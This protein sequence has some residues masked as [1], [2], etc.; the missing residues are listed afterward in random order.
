[1]NISKSILL[2]AFLFLTSLAA[3]SQQCK[4]G[5]LSVPDE[6][7]AYCKSSFIDKINKGDISLES[8]RSTNQICWEVYSDKSENSLKTKPNGYDNGDRLDYMEKVVVKE[9]RGNWLWVYSRI[10][11]KNRKVEH[12]KERGWIKSENLILSGYS[13]L[14]EKSTP[15]K[16]MILV[17]LS[18]IDKSSLHTQQILKNIF[19]NKPNAEAKNA[20]GREARKFEIYFILK[21]TAGAVL[22]SKTDKLN[23]TA[24]QLESNVP[25]WI[26]K[27][28]VTF[29]DHRVCLELASRQQAVSDYTGKDLPVFDTKSELDNFLSTQIYSKKDV[30]KNYQVKP[31]RQDPYEMRMPIIKN[32]DS[33][34]KQVASIARINTGQESTIEI[35]KANVERKIQEVKNKLENVNI[36]FVIDGTQSMSKYY[37]SVASSIRQTIENNKIKGST[38]NLKFGLAIYRD[39]ADGK[40]ALEIEP[41]TTSY[42][43]IIDKV[44]TTNCYSNDND[45]PEAQYNGL[46][47]GIKDAGF[48]PSHSNIVVLV[49]DAGNH[50]PDPKGKKLNDVVQQLFKFQAS[51]VTFQ[52]IYGKDQSFTDFNWDTQDYLMKTAELYVND[53]GKV[54]LENIAVKNT[55][56]LNFINAANKETDLYMFGRFTYA[57]GDRPMDVNLLEQNII[58]SVN[59]YLKRVDDIKSRLEDMT[60]GNAV[61]TDDFIDLLKRKGFSE[62]EIETLKKAKEITAIGNTATRFYDKSEDCFVPVV[63]LSYDEKLAINDILNRLVNKTQST[64]QKKKAFQQALLEQCKKMLGDPSDD[65]ILNKDLNDI[66]DVILSVPFTGSTRLGNTKLRDMDKLDDNTFNG[67]YSGFE[68]AA[69]KFIRNDYRSSRFEL[70]DQKFF[71]IPLSEIPGNE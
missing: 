41:L 21:E 32:Y 34:T 28:N 10:F 36:L 53:K 33:R 1:M 7:N 51:I 62:Q 37:P 17:S 49:G 56:K 31:E 60:G 42:K 38:N 55:Y 6:L 66:W 9:V 59:D 30:I 18:N 4:D 13:L 63:F 35:D 23:G 22:L 11:D 24:K 67:F 65:N 40:G 3:Y 20:T 44:L 2:S 58:E 57:S 69:R 16:A 14:N 8:L 50:N 46:I 25:G 70:A 61:F 19:Y 48:N 27:S 12:D 68:E 45:L 43:S 47:N 54:K 5:Y 71:W 64:T 29:W 15:R 26:P 52:V 39:Y